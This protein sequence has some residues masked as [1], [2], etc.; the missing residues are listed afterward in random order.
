MSPMADS[1]AAAEHP[2]ESDALEFTPKDGKLDYTPTKKDD[3]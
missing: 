3:K 2:R 1:F